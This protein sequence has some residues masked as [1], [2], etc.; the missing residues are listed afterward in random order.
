MTDK[1]NGF[2]ATPDQFLSGAMKMFT[3][4]VTG[5]I[6]TAT[7]GHNVKLDKLIEA[8]SIRAQPVIM[9]TPAGNTTTG[10]LR[11]A[12]EHNEVFGD[13]TAFSTE[14]SNA[15]GF[16]VVVAAFTF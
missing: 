14:V 7:A 16:T 2:V 9:G 6:L 1:V 15:C 12:V 3:A 10:T 5:D 8:L 4:T 11:F 13:L